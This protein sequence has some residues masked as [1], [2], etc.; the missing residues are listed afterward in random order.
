MGARELSA[1][2]DHQGSA[3]APA[4]K[5][6][7]R[8]TRRGRRVFGALATLA[9]SALLAGV[10]VFGSAQAQAN[11][12]GRPA[13]FGYVV[14]QP[15]ESLWA[16]ATRLDAK[17]DPRDLIAEIVQLNQLDGSGVQAGQP[18][19]VPLRYSH[20]TGVVPASEVGIGTNAEL[21]AG[22]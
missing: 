2:I 19:A 14:V 10:A 22:A 17:A 4:A 18:V 6:R 21:A 3:E 1:T 7:L 8:L 11:V 13:D 20:A 15:G 9:V 16:V 12:D 5:S